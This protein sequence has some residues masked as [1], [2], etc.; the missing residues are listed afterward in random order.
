MKKKISEN[1][2]CAACVD[3]IIM[4]VKDRKIIDLQEQNANESFIFSKSAFNGKKL[5]LIRNL[6]NLANELIC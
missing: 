4:K 3:P 6:S 5:I 2:P 1:C